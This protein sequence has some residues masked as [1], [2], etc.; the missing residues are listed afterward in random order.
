[1]LHF[2]FQFCLADLGG[3]HSPVSFLHSWSIR[4]PPQPKDGPVW[5]IFDQ[6]RLQRAL[7]RE[8]GGL[9]LVVEFGGFK[10]FKQ[11]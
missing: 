3:W 1:M 9:A 2:D 7:Q 10:I 8:M 4:L 11:V 5:H 6:Q